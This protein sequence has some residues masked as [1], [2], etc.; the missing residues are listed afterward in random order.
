M[1]EVKNN[2]ADALSRRVCFL[3]ELSVEVVCFERIKEEYESC[4]DFRKIVYM[5]KEGVTPE[6]DGFLL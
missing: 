3:K 5:L 2:V 6:I 4:P 1:S